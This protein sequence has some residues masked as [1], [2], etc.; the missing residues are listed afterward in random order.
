MWA[1]CGVLSRLKW[2]TS[3]SL[4]P[5]ASKSPLTSSY[6]WRVATALMPRHLGIR[7][8][9][10]ER[11][12]STSW[13]VVLCTSIAVLLTT[14]GPGRPQTRP[15]FETPRLHS[16]KIAGFRGSVNSGKTFTKAR[17]LRKGFIFQEKTTRL[18]VRS[19]RST[20]NSLGTLT[21]TTDKKLCLLCR[22]VQCSTTVA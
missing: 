9:N 2:V 15:L 21:F 17:P 7:Q 1:W 5:C 14:K 4:Q 10:V 12:A 20:W 13:H 18:W 16:S 3:E 11:K 19:R 8:S 22:I 6:V